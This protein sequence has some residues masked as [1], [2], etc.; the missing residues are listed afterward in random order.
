MPSA[1]ASIN[2]FAPCASRKR[3]AHEDPMYLYECAP[4]AAALKRRKMFDLD[5]MAEKIR[6]E[7]RR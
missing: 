1:H 2:M 4:E 3:K 6:S 7:K 5:G